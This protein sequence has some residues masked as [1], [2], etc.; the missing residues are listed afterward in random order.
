MSEEPPGAAG[1]V[2]A[3]PGLDGHCA[4][5]PRQGLRE[6]MSALRGVRGASG[7]RL[8]VERDAVSGLRVSAGQVFG[9]DSYVFNMAPGAAG[10]RS[11]RLTAEELDEVQEAFVA[12]DG[13]DS[14]VRG[15]RIRSVTVLRGRPGTGKEAVA[16]T[17]LHRTGHRT[18]HLLDPDTDLTRVGRA[19]LQRG[20]GYVLA[21]LTQRAADALTPFELS[22]L[23]AELR[24]CDCRLVLTATVGVQF[25][26]PRVQQHVVE[27]PGPSAGERI[28]AAHVAW[29]LGVAA[30]ARGRRLLARRDVRELLREELQG[31]GAGAAADLGR[32]LA[33]AA[34]AVADDQVAGRV[35]ERKALQGERAVAHWLQHM[36]NLPQ[37]CLAIGIAAFGGEAYEIVASLARDLEERLQV[38]ES[39]D[40]PVRARGV[41]LMG[42]R[43][44]RLDAVHGTLVDSEV[45]TRHGGARGKVVR[46]RDPG[47]AVKVLEH[48]W[49]EYDE[50]REVLPGWLRDSA[51]GV[52]PTVGVRAAVAAGVLARHGFETVR[53][54]IL[55]PWAADKD[56]ELRDAAAIALG[57]AAKESG[58]AA[59]AYNLVVAWSADSASAEL[60]ATAARAWRVV[61][62]HDGDEQAWA[63]LHHLAGIEKV[64]VVEA[65]CRS[66]TE[67]MALDGG[68]YRSDALDLLDQ[69]AVTGMHGT[70]RRAVGELAFLYAAGDLM[71]SPRKPAVPHATDGPATTPRLWPALL[72]AT[73]RDAAQRAEIAALWRQTVNSAV[74]YGVAHEV[75]TD[76]AALVETDARGRAAL[77][78]LLD[79]TAA[80]RRTELIVRHL[81][82]SW[83]S[84][85][86]GRGAPRSGHHVLTHLDG[87]SGTS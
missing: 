66:L 1:H 53:A 85:T 61:F 36:D 22:R 23:D 14:L 21:G 2:A 63:W 18:L 50:I 3:E 56:A 77:A 46:F 8:D 17:G 28:V 7:E 60:Q 43:T 59:A 73:E 35:R 71:D 72:T 37:Q 64:P 13:F 27:V 41:R 15:M 29:R 33:E 82:E 70:L 67:Y 16:R 57:V 48:I 58:H 19:D 9:G 45:A 68:R 11:Y 87:K 10:L 78:A 51:A 86:D 80:D 12:P 4:P 69:W 30:A 47:L 83:V 32:A 84:G 24:A 52:L 76:W 31:G 49:S 40:N 5:D 75:L 55:Q 44:A 34:D 38:A 20:A 62:E 25:A 74:S 6:G 42:T 39:P 26:D 81:A 54:R 65:L 79:V